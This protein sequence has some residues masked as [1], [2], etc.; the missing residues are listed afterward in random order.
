[1]ISSVRGA[2]TGAGA[3]CIRFTRRYRN[4]ILPGVTVEAKSD[5][6]NWTIG[7]LLQ[8]TAAYL[9]RHGVAEGRLAAEILLARAADCSRIDLY[10]RFDEVPDPSPLTVFREWVRRASAHE[11]VAYIVGQKE[12]FSLSFRV[13]RDV[14]IPR[15]ESEALVE[16]ALDHLGRMNSS[17]PA[18]LDLGTGSGCLAIAILFQHRH[19]TAVATDV[20]AAAL[21]VA[22]ANAE[23]H[24]VSDRITFACADGLALS[25]EL[26]P[27][28]G[29]DLL[30]CN[31]PYVAACEMAGLD[32]VV[33]DYEP[34]VALTDGRDGLTFYGIISERGPALLRPD[35]VV[36]VEVADGRAEAARKAME[37]R[38]A[39]VHRETRRDRVVGQDRVLTFARAGDA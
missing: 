12:F 8:W 26:V 20:S 14:L 15:P 27:P 31:P 4:G 17:P 24:G 25:A 38:G 37:R 18:L 6:T 39:F 34:K 13:T 5:Q 11:P 3:R 2:H 33:R 1:M 10:A 23:R 22:R 35:G 29:F 7:R 9:G 16:C 30:V 21:A 36:V 19:A 32:A 28:G